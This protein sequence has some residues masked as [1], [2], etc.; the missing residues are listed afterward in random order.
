M[1]MS[2]IT[3]TRTNYQT[4]SF[5]HGNIM[6]GDRKVGSCRLGCPDPAVT[7]AWDEDEGQPLIATL[8]PKLQNQDMNDLHN[9]IGKQIIRGKIEVRVL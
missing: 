4:G 5:Y 8:V 6:V 2:T 9:W 1:T 7:L 3:I